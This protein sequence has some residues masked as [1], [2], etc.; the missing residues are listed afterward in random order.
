MNAAFN[1]QIEQ[2]LRNLGFTR[3]EVQ[4]LIYLIR[5]KKSTAR[6]LSRETTIPYGMAKA[7]LTN[8]VRRDLVEVKSLGNNREEYAFRGKEAF[9]QWLR[10]A[11]QQHQS[12]YQQAEQDMSQFFENTE[13]SQWQPE[14]LF[15]EGAEGIKE[16]YEDMLSTGKT[17]H[18]W[19]D[20]ESIQATLGDYM[21]N[22]IEK[23]TEQKIETLA[24]MPESRFNIEHDPNREEMRKIKWIKDLNI[25][26]EIRVYGDKVALMTFDGAKPVGFVFQSKVMAKLFLG[27]FDSVWK[28]EQKS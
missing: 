3:H 16:I 15:Y 19:I 8:L 10:E 12:I 23:R 13:E 21:A 2:S 6:K 9:N 22:F 24:I 27:V 26:G 7:V 20:L 18:S 1:L 14:V 17:L 28:M 11:Q 4:A 25:N 5:V